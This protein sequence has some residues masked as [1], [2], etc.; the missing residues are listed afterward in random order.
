ML[1]ALARRPVVVILFLV[2]AVLGAASARAEPVSAVRLN[3]TSGNRVD[4]AVLGDGYTAAEIASGKYA[5]DVETFVQRVFAQEPYLEYRSY[6]NVRRVDVT[7]AESGSDHPELGS[8]RDTALDGTF[9]C[10]NIERLVCVNQTKV[11]DVLSRSALLASER[12]IILVIVNDTTYGGSG[13]AI[14]VSSTNASSAEIILHELGHSFGLLADEYGGPAPPACNAS[15]EPSAPNATRATTRAAIKWGYWI[16]AATPVP[17]LAALNGVPG[18][19]AGAAYCDTGLYRPTFDSK[20]RSLG[21]PFEA[22]NTEQHVK[23]IYNL[24]DPIDTALPAGTTVTSPAGQPVGFTITVPSPRTHALDIS[25]R[26]DGVLVGSSPGLALDGSSVTAGSHQVSV[27]VRDTTAMCG[28]IPP[29]C[30]R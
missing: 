18:L 22:I 3:G 2:L 26:L 28:A 8:F 4:I 29:G 30:C 20:M 13:G 12:D 15:V 21:R 5:N 25:W 27:T 11:N 7:S 19:Y 16:D 1:P 9:N 10:S 23:R 24:V 6:F 14:A 17:T